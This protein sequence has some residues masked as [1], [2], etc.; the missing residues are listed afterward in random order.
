MNYFTEE[1]TF[2]PVKFRAAVDYL[3][4]PIFPGSIVL[5]VLGHDDKFF[6][7]AVIGG[8][9]SLSD[10]VVAA[11]DN[12]RNYINPKSHYGRASAETLLKESSRRLSAAICGAKQN[13]R[14]DQ[15][16]RENFDIDFDI[17]AYQ[18]D[19]DFGPVKNGAWGSTFA[20]GQDVPDVPDWLCFELGQES[21]GVSSWSPEH[22]PQR[23]MDFWIKPP[24]PELLVEIARGLDIE[25]RFKKAVKGERLQAALDLLWDLPSAGHSPYVPSGISNYGIHLDRHKNYDSEWLFCMVCDELTGKVLPGREKLAWVLVNNKIT[26]F[27]CD[28]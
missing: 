9:A 21:D 17:Y 2:K 26:S 24:R 12:W 23:R 11:P 1:I 18:R 27:T 5:G 4:N 16:V 28:W 3:G 20:L 6:G 14:L 8:E 15:W 19:H 10:P 22:E 25:E 13:K 7:A